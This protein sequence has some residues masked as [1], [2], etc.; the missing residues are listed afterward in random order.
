MVPALTGGRNCFDANPITQPPARTGSPLRSDNAVVHGVVLTC[1]HT[2]NGYVNTGYQGH[3]LRRS[4]ELRLDIPTHRR[5]F[6]ATRGAARRGGFYLVFLPGNTARESG[7]ILANLA[8][9]LRESTRPSRWA[10]PSRPWGS[11]P[12]FREPRRARWEGATGLAGGAGRGPPDQRRGVEVRAGSS[13]STPLGAR[14][15]R[16]SLSGG[17]RKPRNTSVGT[18]TTKRQPEPGSLSTSMLPPRRSISARTASRPTPRPEVSLTSARVER[19]GANSARVSSSRQPAGRPRSLAPSRCRAR[20][21]RSRCAFRPRPG[22]PGAG[23]A[24]NSF[25]PRSNRRRISASGMSWPPAA[26]RAVTLCTAKSA[27]GTSM[28]W[29]M[30]W[31]PE[32][33]QR[34][35]SPLCGVKSTQQFA[36]CCHR[37]SKFG[38]LEPN[39]IRVQ[40][41]YAR[42]KQRQELTREGRLPRAVGSRHSE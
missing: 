3:D 32:A 27:E 31:Y 19:A 33:R 8:F 12:A 30:G 4:G 16:R 34:S 15:G 41:R 7:W 28:K 17:R 6:R 23:R 11:D 22:L 5:N 24:R 1:T 39:L 38:S 9:R 18:R 42:V 10:R 20:R 37:G 26:T 13:S 29:M 25:R 2:P 35:S 36:T 14:L 40:K 21:R